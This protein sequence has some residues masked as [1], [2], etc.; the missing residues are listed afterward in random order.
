MRKYKLKMMHTRKD[1]HLKKAK[2]SAQDFSIAPELQF[3]SQMLMGYI[4]V[5]EEAASS[6]K[7]TKM[8]HQTCYCPFS[9]FLHIKY[10]DY[11]CNF[12][13]KLFFVPCR[14][15]QTLACYIMQL[16]KY[17]IYALDTKPYYHFLLGNKDYDNR[18]LEYYLLG[19]PMRSVHS[20]FGSFS[21]IS[22]TP[23]QRLIAALH[24]DAMIDAETQVPFPRIGS[25]G[26]W[27]LLTW[28]PP[29]LETASWQ[30]TGGF[31][32]CYLLRWECPTMSSLLSPGTH[33][34]GALLAEGHCKLCENF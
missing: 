30:Q 16:S 6:F 25:I 1:G 26:F 21:H 15:L 20:D 10:A 2:D 17:L 13:F 7:H 34:V 5:Q 18:R 29:A 12:G 31:L 3:Q 19:I 4:L 32:D 22:S 11:Q 27:N 23:P 24:Q 14:V 9:R 33:L 28:L 8:Q